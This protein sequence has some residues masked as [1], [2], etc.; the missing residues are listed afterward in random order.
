MKF[1]VGRLGTGIDTDSHPVHVIP[2]GSKGFGYFAAQ[3]VAVRHHT[4]P[5]ARV[6]QQSQK[7]ANFAVG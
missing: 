5:K 7:L 4:N 2:D 6:S 1:G 3:E